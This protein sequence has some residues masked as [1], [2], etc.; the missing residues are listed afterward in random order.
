MINFRHPEEWFISDIRNR[1]ILDNRELLILHTRTIVSSYTW[2]KTHE[3]CQN[4][5]LLVRWQT[6][7]WEMEGGKQKLEVQRGKSTVVGEEWEVKSG[8]LKVRD[9]K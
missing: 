6:W 9:G 7:K 5:I 4:R 8:K 1:S 2:H 3:C